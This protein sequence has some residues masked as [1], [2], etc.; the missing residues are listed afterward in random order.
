MG[1]GQRWA[2]RWMKGPCLLCHRQSGKM[3]WRTQPCRA[4]SCGERRACSPRAALARGRLSPH[5]RRIPKP[6]ALGLRR[7]AQSRV[8]LGTRR[9][10]RSSPTCWRFPEVQGARTWPGG[11]SR[12]PQFPRSFLSFANQNVARGRLLSSKVS[13]S[14]Q[15]VP[16]RLQKQTVLP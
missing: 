11:A 7:S 13:A 5:P 6:P 8:L 16:G 1:R 14:P 9:E 4:R 3:A 12:P 10:P 15:V 2:G